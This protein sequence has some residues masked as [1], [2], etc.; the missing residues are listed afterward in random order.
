[1]TFYIQLFRCVLWYSTLFLAAMLF[2]LYN[3]DQ[4]YMSIFI[5]SLMYEEIKIKKIP[6]K[7]WKNLERI[8]TSKEC[9]PTFINVWS[10]PER[11]QKNASIPNTFIHLPHIP[12]TSESNLWKSLSGR[13]HME[14]AGHFL[15]HD[16]STLLVYFWYSIHLNFDVRPLCF[17]W[18][19]LWNVINSKKPA[20]MRLNYNH[21]SR[22][23]EYIN[24][25]SFQ[26]YN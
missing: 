19:L 11:T 9:L 23:S 4:V 13:C 18:S 16:C 14:F 15:L 2:S 20:G 25:L 17:H 5:C 6:M 24:Q 10:C 26:N 1:M 8:F 22:I 12:H 7:L 21:P 3:L